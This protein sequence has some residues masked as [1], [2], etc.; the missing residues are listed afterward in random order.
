[1]HSIRPLG[2]SERT[3][4]L[5][6]QIESVRPD[7]APLREDL[8]LAETPGGGCGWYPRSEV[9][10][11]WRQCDVVPWDLLDTQARDGLGVEERWRR[12]GTTLLPVNR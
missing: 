8:A 1:L 11:A 2:R 10:S 9:R 5:L 3:A 6:G 12:S 4:A 7:L